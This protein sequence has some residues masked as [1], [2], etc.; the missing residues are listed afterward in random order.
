MPARLHR[1][2]PI[3]SLL[4]FAACGTAHADPIADLKAFSVIKDVNLEKLASGSI[5]AV[6]GPAM[7]SPR[8]LAIE[9]C[10]VVRKPLQKTAELHVQWVPTKHR[11]LK[12]FLHGDLTSP[13]TLAQFQQLS[14]APSN[15]AVKWFAATTE[16]LGD[17]AGS[18]QLTAAEAKAYKPDA[19]SGRGGALPAP[20][21]A[22][23]SGVLHRR[24]EAFL[25]GGLGRLPAYEMKGE[26]IRSSEEIAR[27]LKGAAKVRAQFS[28]LLEE[29]ALTGGKGSL[30]PSAYWEMFDA[31]GEGALNLGVSYQRPGASTWQSVDAQ[32][33]ASG[34]YYAMLTFY[35]MWPVT[36][37]GQE[38]TLVWRGDLISSQALAAL[39]G[40]ERMGSGTAMM[41]ETQKSIKSLLDDAAKAK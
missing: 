11:E 13:S 7:S 18:L 37:G 23:W 25:S 35:Q 16:K 19:G 14:E 3:A 41:R 30:K 20:V 22:F 31:E 32:Y 5:T 12:V 15:G 21:V 29:T 6:R 33:Y 40:V 4:V 26:T 8:D 24:A 34:A 38:C 9:S 36:V 2:L 1:F 10:Y 17:S 39:H 28:A 27:L